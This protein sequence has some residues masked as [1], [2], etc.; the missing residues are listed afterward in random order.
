MLPPPGAASLVSDPGIG[1]PQSFLPASFEQFYPW[2]AAQHKQI[3]GT[4]LV[5][6][7]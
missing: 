6:P 4:G 1:I 3:G 5:S 2:T 7:S